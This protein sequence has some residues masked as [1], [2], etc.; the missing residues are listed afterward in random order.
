MKKQVNEVCGKIL[1]CQVT[2]T[3]ISLFSESFQVLDVCSFLFCFVLRFSF[4]EVVSSSP[5]DAVFLL[6]CTWRVQNWLFYSDGRRGCVC[7]WSALTEL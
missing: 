6:G 5:A 2:H 3:L 4:K 1:V 7:L